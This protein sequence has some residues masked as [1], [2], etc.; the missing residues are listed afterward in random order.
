MHR[1]MQ[2]YSACHLLNRIRALQYHVDKYSIGN[3]M[4]PLQ[5]TL[6]K[7]KIIKN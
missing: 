6:Q 4:S 5:T 1:C 2:V 7:K 3:N